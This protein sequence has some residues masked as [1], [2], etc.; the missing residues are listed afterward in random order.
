MSTY[1]SAED[2][3]P[4][5]PLSEVQRA[6]SEDRFEVPARVARHLRSRGWDREFVQACVRDLRSE[7]FHTTQAHRT[8]G[9]AW[10]DVYRPYRGDQRLYVKVT[11]YEQRG[12]FLL[13]SFCVDGTAH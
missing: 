3:R 11:V 10:L 9:D 8:R 12:T 2:R 4:H 6:F 5:Y 7:D 1:G 13:L